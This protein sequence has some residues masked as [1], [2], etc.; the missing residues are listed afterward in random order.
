MNIRAIFL[1]T[2]LG[3][4]FSSLAHAEEKP[5]QP[6]PPTITNRHVNPLVENGVNLWVRGDALFWQTSE[7]NLLNCYI[8]NSNL[9]LPHRDFRTIHFDWDVGFR[10]GAGYD[11]PHDEWD[12]TLF[13]THYDTN[14]KSS[15]HTEGSEH[16]ASPT[17]G[18]SAVNSQILFL[19]HSKATFHLS[20]NQL[21]LDL[22]RSYFVGNYFTLRPNFGLRAT[23]INQNLNIH[24]IAQDPDPS[25]KTHLKNDF[26]GFG[27]IAGLD[28]N[29]MFT[30]RWS[31][32][33][34]A[35]FSILLGSFNLNQTGKQEGSTVWSQKKHTQT[36]K[37]VLDIE[38]GFK[39]SLLFS[40]NRYAFTFRAGYEYHLYFNQNQFLLSNGNHNFENFSTIK[41]NLAF[42]GVMISGQFDF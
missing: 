8:I 34:D 27:L 32:Y 14:A 16:I 29:W 1:L 10:I 33:G 30:Q 11:L 4:M 20:L 19:D 2:I 18:S 37:G 40:K 21:D 9:T 3:S 7:D 22:G 31:L 35:D 39:Y 17:W 15:V 28:A 42:Q 38:A 24:S 23:W 25:V 12:L 41:G 36:G 6:L 26:W 5:A 13:W